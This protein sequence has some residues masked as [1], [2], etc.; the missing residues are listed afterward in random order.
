[1]AFADFL[2]GLLIM[3]S[4]LVSVYSAEW[5]LGI[6]ACKIFAVMKVAITLASIYSLSGISLQRY[7]YVVKRTERMNKYKKRN[8][9]NRFG[10][11]L[12]I[13]SICHSIIWM[14]SNW[15]RRWKRS[16]YGF[17]SFDSVAHVDGFYNWIVI[18]RPC[19]G[20]M[21]RFYIPNSTEK[22]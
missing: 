21:L 20:R 10:L 14:G 16:L 1:M 19:D 8:F 15:I 18:K 4:A 22:W 6:F 2:Q 5:I 3:P 9:W 11:V 12:I 13:V 17:I 7:F